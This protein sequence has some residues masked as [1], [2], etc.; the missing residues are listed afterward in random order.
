MKKCCHVSHVQKLVEREAEHDVACLLKASIF[1][2]Q[3]DAYVQNK[4]HLKSTVYTVCSDLYIIFAQT[5][6]V[7]SVVPDRNLAWRNCLGP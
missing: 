2:D 3:I 4:Y 7:E 1:I 5:F 6:N